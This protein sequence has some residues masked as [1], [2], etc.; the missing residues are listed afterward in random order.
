MAYNSLQDFLQVL[1]REGELKR[2]SH[3]VKAELQIP[4]IADRVMKAGGPALLFEN[5]V[6]KNIPVLINAFG[7]TKRMALALGVTNIEEIAAEITKLIQTRPPK[8]FKD[9]LQ[10]LGELVKLAGIPPKMVKEAACQEVVHR[11]PDLNLLPVLTCWPGDAGPFITL[12]MVFSK[13]P[14]KGTRNVGLYRMQVFDRRTTGMHWHLHKVSA[15]HFQQQKENQR[16]LELAV[17]LGGDPAM[18]YAAT[19]PLPPQ[20]DE[21]LFTGFLRKKGVELVKGLTVDIEVPANSDIV[22]EGYVDPAEPLRREGPFGDHTGFYSLA[23]DYPVFHVTCITHRK[24]PIYPTTIVGRPPMEDAYL[25]KATERLFLPLLRVTLPEIVDMNLPVH[26]VF[27]NLAIISIKKEYPAHGRKVMHALW[28]LGQMM[29][30]KTL[31]VVDHDVNVHDLAEVTWVVG[32]HIEPKR[33]T[34]FSEGPVDVLDHAAP[35]LGYGSKLGIDATRKWRS[36]GFERE[37][38][39]AIVMDDRTK[40]YIDS[41]WNK[42][43][44]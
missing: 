14:S 21:I 25:G 7:S 30:T 32:N 6:G 2:I 17:C 31:I 10:L 43:G 40:S 37:W 19:A 15:R 12:P 34:I 29:F 8:S 3:P 27:H 35:L 28:G 22:I 26:G 9:K 24:N 41:I 39:D 1:A 23:D 13:D 36:E 4:E 16:K 5:V 42:L 44:I 38:P 18:I 33:D 20:I 11:D